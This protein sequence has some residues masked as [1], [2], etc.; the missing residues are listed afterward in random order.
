M[1]TQPDHFAARCGVHD[2]ARE[3]ACER[4]IALVRG[5]PLQQVRLT[6]FDVHGIARSKSLD[7]EAAVRA[8]HAGIGMVSTL[9]LKDTSDRTA[10]KVFEPGGIATLDGFGQANNLQLLPDPDSLRQLPW[11]P[12]TG[13]LRC[14]PWWHDGTPVALN[15]R[16][17][18]SAAL[19][20][21][22][23]KGLDLRCGLEVEFHIYRI[24]DARAQ[25]DPLT[26][27]WPGAA[28]DVE[29][30]HPGYQ[31]LGEAWADLADMPM[32]LVRNTAMAL[33]LPLE[34]LE[35]ELGPSQVEAVFGVTDAM[36]AA[37]NL[38][39]FRNAVRQ[40]LRR[41]GYHAT[42]M[43]RPPFP[44]IMSSGWH[45]HQSLVDSDSLANR[46]MVP[47]PNPALPAPPSRGAA[48]VLSATGQHYLAGL[49][50]HARG[51]ALLCTPTANGFA[52]F[53]PHMLAP[54]T[55]VWGRDNRGAMLRVIGA[56]GDSGT[57]IE[58]RIGDPSANPYLYMASQIHA[59]L[60]G[61]ERE[62][63]PPPATDAPYAND[64]LRLPASLGEAIEALEQ[65]T[66]LCAAI[67]EDFIRWLLQVKRAEWKRYS[68]ADD[69]MRFDA[70]EYF[71]RI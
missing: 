65:D 6:W 36:T 11:A 9:M 23:A 67:G 42:F 69:P 26:A 40:A 3:V 57:R 35:I 24:R 30:V 53:R 41:I 28:P 70:R 16:R 21:L 5:T 62:L 61:I 18:L 60:D 43:C 38:N 55:A 27:D 46:M 32:A 29:L 13:W 58:N 48:T 10:F 31:L 1:S 64:A 14:D 54:L 44:N 37:D 2:A 19:A 45:L 50:A 63:A 59:G 51:M 7:P 17:V 56:P 4:A 39:L 47:E 8:L 20:R 33:G 71:S 25:L 66:G 15:P 34:S 49:L 68:E 12:G 52:R 22:R